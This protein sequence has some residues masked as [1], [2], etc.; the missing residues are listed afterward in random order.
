MFNYRLVFQFLGLLLLIEGFFMWLCIPVS[1]LFHDHELVPLGVSGLISVVV[2]G[3]TLLATRK[4]PKILNARDGFLI[5]A[6]GWILF[7]FFGSMPFILSG[8]IPS[9]TDAFFETISGFT[10]TGASILSEI[11]VLPHGLLFWRSLTQWLGGM[12][13]IVMS[14]A[15]LP[16]LGVGGMQLF[17]AE[18]PGPVPDKLH[19]R[20]KETAKRLWAI[21]I[22]FTFAETLLLWIGGMT[23]F[24]AVNH[25][26]TTMATG[27]YST[28]TASLAYW[29]SP[30]IHYVIVIF[31]F[32]AGTNFTLSYF[33]L[34]LRFKKVWQ[35]EEF[36]YYL[37]FILG[38]TI[39]LTIIL[40]FT[41]LQSG[42][43]S[44]RHSLFQVV[45]IITTTGFVTFDYLSWI[46]LLGIILFMMMFFGGSAGST[47]GGIKILRIVLLLKN[48]AMELKRLI[49][50]NAVIPVRFNKNAV[51]PDILNNVFAF[52]SFYIMTVIVGVIVMTA[53]GY[54]IGSALGA[55]A[56]TLGNIGPGIGLVG[57]VENY[58]H[59]PVFGKWFLSFLMLIGR[60]ELFT[61]LILFSPSFWK[62]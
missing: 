41:E 55:V 60:L 45:S 20:I 39:L 51:S 21:Y 29:D 34:H 26:F 3:L 61:V 53:M 12:G 13:I 46:P 28:K 10:T 18:V 52:I 49:H 17:V 6:I 54:D 7:S 27:G 19:P 32:L 62:K 23:L 47:G 44:F 8:E 42:E 56:A 11:E 48:S 43:E 15:I 33:A 40:S 2:G 58:A 30:F 5:V 50:P 22:I 35:N 16:L 9:F 1:M 57:P 38:F 36:R 37:G 25:S 59:I 31:M 24:D 4:A 14:L